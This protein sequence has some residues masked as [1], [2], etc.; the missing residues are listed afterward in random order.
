MIS[1]LAKLTFVA[2]TDYQLASWHCKYRF[3]DDAK[4]YE[5]EST[6]QDARDWGRIASLMFIFDK[7]LTFFWNKGE[8]SV[9]PSET[10]EVLCGNPNFV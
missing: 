4:S 6:S 1:F 7:T 3:Y 5:N 8:D 9:I 2:V 10:E